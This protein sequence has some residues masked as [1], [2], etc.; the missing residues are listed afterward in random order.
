VCGDVCVFGCEGGAVVVRRGVKWVHRGTANQHT[1][2]G[3][4]G[5]NYLVEASFILLSG[6]ACV[7][8]WMSAHALL[9]LVQLLRV[10]LF[11]LSCH[12]FLRFS[13]LCDARNV[14]ADLVWTLCVVEVVRLPA[15]H[16]RRH[17]LLA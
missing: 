13:R 15:R 17:L 5:Q 9:D 7:R 12:L 11:V 3:D 8:A 1:I 14:L 2:G 6:D 16:H 4:G 10:K